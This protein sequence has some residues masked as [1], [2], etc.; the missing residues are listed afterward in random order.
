MDK[1]RDIVYKRPDFGKLR[2]EATAEI[3][4]LTKAESY[5]EA[6]AAYMALEKLMGDAMTMSTVAYIR[7]TLDTTDKFYDGEMKF[8]NRA[9]A[10]LMPLQKKLN[11]AFLT[12]RFRPDF[13]AE[14]GEQV[15][16]AMELEDRLQSKKIIADTIRE[17]LLCN[18]YKKLAASC[19][20]EFMGKECNFYGL[21]KHMESADREER[22]AAYLAWAGLYEGVSERLDRIYDKLLAL[23]IRMAG[24]LGLKDYTEMAYMNMGRMDYTREDVA[25]FREQVRQVIVPAVA[26]Y[27]ERQARRIG[28]DKLRYYDEAFVFPDGNA[29]PVGGQDV[30]VPIA[31]R[32]YRELSPETGEF[33]DF[34]CEHELFDL[35]TRPGKHLG[36]YCTELISFRAPFIFS[37]FNGTAADAGVLTHEA[38]HAFA[39]YTAAKHQP[40]LPYVSSTSEINEIHSMSM[41]HFTYPWLKDLFGAENAE[42]A[43]FTHLVD[44]LST[45]P[46]LVSV[47]EFQHRVYE[48]P[49]MSAKERR[50]VWREI[51]KKYMPWRD[52][53]GM[54]FLEEGGF[55]MQK[56]HIFLYP[57]YYIDYALAQTCAFQFYGMMKREPAAAWERYMTLCRAGGSRGYFELLELA[58]LENPFREGT[59]ERAVRHVIE[60]LDD[61]PFQA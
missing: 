4:R 10:L 25:A 26:R 38:G 15:F 23:R 45:I 55:W 58:G 28:V 21:L 34:M 43:R 47:D 11:R 6:K 49:S 30:L 29:D 44:A 50:G 8:F 13:T 12:S 31:Q 20:T 46:Y 35:E 22:R 17:G 51:E 33:F 53:D 19:K 24:K 39:G 42:K 32:M 27:K 37:N 36:G 5:A 2:R 9:G 48:K 18:E 60:E 57:F 1:F 40:I 16:K 41:E 7:N 3:R 14:Y 54:P 61:S 59:V 56:Q 52:Y